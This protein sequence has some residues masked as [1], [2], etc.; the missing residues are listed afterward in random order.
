[1]S[2]T[3]IFEAVTAD[4]ILRCHAVFTELRPHL[5][6]PAAFV[7]QVQRQIREGGYNLIYRE[8]EGAVCAV[9]GY[10]ISEN[11]AWGKFLY[12]D[13]LITGTAF[14]KQGNARAML[15]WLIDVAGHQGC[16]QLHLD[17]GVQRFDAHR[18][19]LNAGMRITSHH[20]GLILREHD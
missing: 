11:L 10:R 2:D 9:A 4:E 17:S 14:R 19:Y 8:C 3:S 6:E 20:F 16:A 12:V 13:D 18:L 5:T 1:M 7:E 15:D